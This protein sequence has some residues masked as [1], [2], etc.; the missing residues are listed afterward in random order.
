MFNAVKMLLL[1][2]IVVLPVA[3]QSATTNADSS[4]TAIIKP[5]TKLSGAPNL[6][7]PQKETAGSLAANEN[8]SKSQEFS[9]TASIIDKQIFLKWPSYQGALTFNVYRKDGNDQ[10]V[11]IASVTGRAMSYVDAHPGKQSVYKVQP[12]SMQGKGPM[13]PEVVPPA[14]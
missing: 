6:S 14:R 12:V 2:N 3:S 11:Q 13:S 8:A 1:L 9:P 7:G 10:F 5:I 4:R